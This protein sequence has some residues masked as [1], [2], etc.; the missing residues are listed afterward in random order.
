MAQYRSILGTA[1]FFS[2]KILVTRYE[3]VFLIGLLLTG[4]HNMINGFFKKGPRQSFLPPV[5]TQVLQVGTDDHI[6]AQHASTKL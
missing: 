3:L 5:C 1:A 6:L 4:F 2:G